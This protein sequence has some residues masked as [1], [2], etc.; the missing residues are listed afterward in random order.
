MV[1]TLAS[2]DTSAY[3]GVKDIV[4]MPSIVDV[5]GINRLSSRILTNA[6]GAIAG[7]VKVE[8]PTR[9]ADK[10]LHRRDHVRRDHA[11]RDQGARGPR[12]RP[13]TRC[14]SS[15]PSESAGAPWRS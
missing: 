12:S 2:G 11:V 15:T 14:S 13:A 10:P 1:S 3:V 6:A 7:M 5:A 9:R 8:Q 4:M